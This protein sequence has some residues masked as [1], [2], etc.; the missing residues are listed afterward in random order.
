MGEKV[1][2]CKKE[3]DREIMSNVECALFIAQP[4]VFCKLQD[5]LSL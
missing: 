3:T 4:A 5:A 2:P 1:R